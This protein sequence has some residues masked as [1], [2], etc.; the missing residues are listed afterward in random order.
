MNPR[1]PYGDS[2]QQRRGPFSRWPRTADALLAVVIFIWSVFVTDDVPD[3]DLAIRAASELPVGAIALYA[4]ASVALYWRRSRPI[5]VLAAGVVALILLLLLGYP[6]DMWALPFA[7]YSVGRYTTNDKKS[8]VVIGATLAITAAVSYL[9]AAPASDVIFGMI[10]VF[11][12]WYAGRSI[13]IRSEFLMERAAQL[14]REHAAEAR[15]AV[16]EE[17]TRIA[18]ELHDIVAHRVSLMTVQ[19]GAAKTVAADNLQS[20]LQA[21]EAVESAGREALD[22]LRHLLGVLRPASDINDLGPQPG[23]ADVPRLVDDIKEAGLAVTLETDNMPSELPARV[24]LAIYR[25]VQEALT[26]VLKHAGAN[27]TADVRLSVD[28]RGIVIEVLDNGH[29]T[30][31]LPGSGHGIA[32]MR[33][34]AELLGGHL[35]AGPRPDGGFQVLVHLPIAEEST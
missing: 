23:V 10:F 2:L 30:T 27:V 12:I 19:A 28:E 24:D 16:A 20:A 18:R 4:L 25:I 34:R 15:R 26:N 33:E 22:E 11:L 3:Q 21:M 14:E 7:L 8:Y 6:H 5:E 13:R 17:R 29:G 31:V 1:T 32:G 9:D 35:D